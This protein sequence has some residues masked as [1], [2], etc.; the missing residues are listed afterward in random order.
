MLEPALLLL[1]L[2]ISFILRIIPRFR[3]KHAYGG[4]TFFHLHMGQEIRENRFKLPQRIPRVTLPHDYTYPYLYHLLLALFPLRHRLWV[5][6]TT[7]A[8]FDTFNVLLVYFFSRW[9]IDFYNIVVTPYFPVYIAL[10][11]A[12][13]PGLLT[14][15]G[16]PRAYNGS[17]RVFGQALYLVHITSFFYYS[18]TGRYPA[19]AVSIVSGSLIFFAAKFG[20]QVL[21]FFGIVFGIFLSPFYFAVLGASFIASIIISKGRVVRVLY[22]HIRH[23]EF[24]TKYVKSSGAAEWTSDLSVFKIYAVRFYRNLKEL[25]KGKVAAFT[26]WFTS[27]RFFIHY[28]IVSYPQIILLLFIY[29]KFDL[30]EYYVKF[31]LIWAGAS[32]IWFLLTSVSIFKF[33]GEAERYL[34]YSLPATLFLSCLYLVESGLEIII[35]LFAVYSFIIY[36]I[37]YRIFIKRYG[38]QDKNYEADEEFFEKVRSAPEGVILPINNEW[39]ILYRSSHPVLTYGANID[40]SRISMREFRHIYYNS[41]MPAGHLEEFAEKFNVRYI[42]TSYKSLD[43]YLDEVFKDKEKFFSLIKKKIEGKNFLLLEV[44]K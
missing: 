25:F 4:D 39:Q 33:L 34:E 20:V 43:S 31:L 2:F 21:V 12:L 18:L 37:H 13:F 9:I 16:G 17:P 42:L 28:V 29:N 26:E 1:I 30:N 35:P 14:V 10:L 44:I 36:L 23:S 3:L 40:L 8:F 19:L 24:Y 32:V 15:G 11:M 7:G 22:G 41:H 5:E 6:R 27:E 38:A